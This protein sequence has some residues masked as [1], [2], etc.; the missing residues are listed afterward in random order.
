MLGTTLPLILALAGPGGPGDRAPDRAWD[1]QH[2]HLDLDLDPSAGRVE[3][4][5]TLTLS[6]LSPPA[7]EIVLDQ[8]GL[9]IRAVT[10]DGQ[11]VPFRPD[12][13]HLHVTL[14]PAEGPIQVE[15]SYA[16]TPDTGLHFRGPGLRSPDTYLE[17]WSQ[18]E[19][20]DNRHWLPL[21]DHPNDRFTTSGRFTAPEGLSVLSNG[22]GSFDGEAW[23]YQ[24]DE[25][26]V[27]Y[28]VMVAAGPYQRLEGSWRGRPVEQW[29]PPD[30]E[31]AHA[32]A[33]GAL[34]PGMLDH[35]SERTGLEYPYPAYREVYVQRFLYTGMENTTSTVIHRRLLGYARSAAAEDQSVGLG[36]EIVVAHEL[37]HQWYGDTLTC[38][39]WHELW[40][41]E[42]FAH[43]F[44]D[45]WLRA[46]HGEATHAA[47][48]LRGL[49]AALGAGVLAGR[50]WSTPEGEHPPNSGVYVKGA[51]LLRMLQVRYGE[52]AFWAAIRRYTTTSSA[53]G[54]VET[55]DLRRAFEEVTGDHLGWFFDQWAHLPGA[56]SL[57]VSPRWS[58][59]ELRVQVSQT[60]PSGLA[61]FV[62]EL[63]LEI[64]TADGPIHRRVFIDGAQQALQL[65]LESPPLYVAADPRGG[66]LAAITNTQS[67]EMWRAQLA[68]PAPY[69]QLRALRQGAATERPEDW[70]SAVLPMA[71]HAEEALALE[72]IA[73]LGALDLPEGNLVLVEIMETPSST[74]E[75]RIAAAEALGKGLG[76]A[77]VTAGLSRQLRSLR[78]DRSLHGRSLAAAALRSLSHLDRDAGRAEA[79]ALLSGEPADPVQDPAASAALDVLG[80]QRRPEDLSLALRWLSPRHSTDVLHA[81]VSAA[82][83]IA[84]AT[85]PGPKRQA[86]LSEVARKVE[87]L[88]GDAFQRTRSHAI[89]ALG[90]VGDEDS[91]RAL[92]AFIRQEGVEAL[93]RQAR[94][95]ISLIRGRS[96]TP[97]PSD[98]ALGG[99]LEDLERRLEELTEELQAL[100]ER[101]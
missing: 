83:R 98:A 5:V 61:P 16:A 87:P 9:E 78:R 66:L 59:G 32:R 58:E 4:S 47:R 93:R 97:L 45:D 68:S 49:D 76:A 29:L 26:L 85:E 41:N 10:R 13:E 19:D 18:G 35:L 89:S 3:G 44:A 77:E 88:L 15:V 57:E 34:L 6:P 73:T 82:E 69:A 2:L 60:P 84:G 90:K 67:P 14:G 43:F 74:I 33:L 51:A 17:L 25:D 30:A 64:G 79:R 11:A 22:L 42:G 28:L 38:R 62:M 91:V 12:G 100:Q 65:D 50:F 75:R 92:E 37:A 96:D 40:L 71:T 7:E 81:A 27:S 39:T 63:E 36:Y 72:A 24:M 54:L 99:R 8:I 80:A 31:P 1:L 70:L 95:A 56:P 48:L 20:E 21:P 94:R 46:R 86:R 52:E 53:G 23:T 101:I 55:D